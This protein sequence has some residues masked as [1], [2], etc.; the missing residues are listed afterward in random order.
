MAAPISKTLTNGVHALIGGDG[1]A[2]VCLPGWPQTAAAFLDV[3]PDLSANHKVL[4]IDPPGLGASAAPPNDD[5]TAAAVIAAI[6]D[7]IGA[8][9]TYDLVGH[10]VGSW[11]SFS[12]AAQDA[13]HVRSLTLLDAM[14]SGLSTPPPFP[15]PDEINV[16]L[17]QF[18]FNRLPGGLPEEL[19][20]G[21]E[22]FL[23]DWLFDMK[24]VHPERIT[25]ERRAEY[26]KAY[27]SEG[28]MSRGFA[29]YRAAGVSAVQ[30]Q[31]VLQEGKLGMPVLC[32]AGRDGQG[33]AMKVVAGSISSQ[34]EKSRFVLLEDCG[35]Y[36]MEEQPEE[37]AAAVLDFIG[38]V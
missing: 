16:R 26:V 35:H 9:T 4:I 23:L 2:L 33:E 29:Y 13:A 12:I 21:K 31:K 19:V 30:N 27:A 38:T 25:K 37:T 11:M 22:K 1:P 14:I 7:E 3:Y 6:R 10:D 17:W 28:G 18:N 15:L 36:V 20:K 8:D 34:E 32:V 24:A 5:Y